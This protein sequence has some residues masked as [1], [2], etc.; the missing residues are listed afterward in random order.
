MLLT[1]V[2]IYPKAEYRDIVVD[3]F[4]SLKGP[5]GSVTECLECSVTVETDGDSEVCY[6]EKW[7][8]RESLEAHL[9]SVNFARILQVM[10][11]SIIPPAMNFYV[12]NEIG[13]MGLVENIRLPKLKRGGN[14]KSPQD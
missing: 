1:I 4:N 7:Q 14:Q 3:V 9:G 2:K 11:Y 5:L 6:M 10:E 13:G 8:T 12:L